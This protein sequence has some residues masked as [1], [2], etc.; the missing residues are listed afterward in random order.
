M[1][2]RREKMLGKANESLHKKENRKKEIE[3]QIENKQGEIK[4]KKEEIK[5][6]NGTYSQTL[7]AISEFDYKLQQKISSRNNSPA[8]FDKKI[9]DEQKRKDYLNN[10]RV[11]FDGLMNNII[12]ESQGSMEILDQLC[13]ELERTYRGLI[14]ESGVKQ[15]LEEKC[16]E[17]VEHRRSLKEQRIEKL[18]NEIRQIEKEIED[19]EKEKKRAKEELSEIQ[20]IALEIKQDIDTIDSKLPEHLKGTKEERDK[21]E[22]KK[23][24]EK[25]K[26][27]KRLKKHMK[28][29]E[30]WKGVMDQAGKGIVQLNL[31]DK[32]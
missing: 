32:L 11:F 14:G 4:R 23:K 12:Q 15:L 17:L 1:K 30:K 3:G 25:R 2:L 8:N 20:G 31:I 13:L 6:L 18:E 28:A 19:F 29:E 5:K 22:Q 16:L 24:K 21:R 7:K 10:N 27:S 9:R 26:K